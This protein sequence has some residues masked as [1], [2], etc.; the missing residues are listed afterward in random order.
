MA[1]EWRPR[2]S[3]ISHAAQ[4]RLH[5]RGPHQPR[6]VN[7]VA[8]DK[9]ATTGAYLDLRLSF[10]ELLDGLNGSVAFRHDKNE[11]FDKHMLFP[12]MTKIL[13]EMF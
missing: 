8:Q 10:P 9:V 13:V 12:K 6:V 2:S 7:G 4:G 11:M 1:A 3:C 5:V